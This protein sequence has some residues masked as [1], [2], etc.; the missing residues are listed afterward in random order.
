MCF[1][2]YDGFSKSNTLEHTIA[3][4][5]KLLLIPQIENIGFVDPLFFLRGG[6]GE[7]WGALGNPVLGPSVLHCKW[8]LRKMR[9]RM[10]T[11][12]KIMNQNGES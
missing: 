10:G 5:S 4:S 12:F 11:E 7:T 1:K 9:S 8:D 3:Y 2:N 6:C